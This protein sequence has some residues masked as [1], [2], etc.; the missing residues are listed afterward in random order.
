MPRESR[1][2]RSAFVA[3]CVILKGINFISRMFQILQLHNIV[4]LEIINDKKLQK[5]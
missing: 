1:Y 2:R 4:D 3:F 5:H